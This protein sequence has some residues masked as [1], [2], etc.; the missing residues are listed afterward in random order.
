MQT[1]KLLVPFS[2]NAWTP[3]VSL[4][5]ADRSTAEGFHLHYRLKTN[6]P[7]LFAEL[8]RTPAAGTPLRRDELWRTTCFEAFFGVADS[9]AYF[10]L[11]LTPSGDWAW[12]AFDDYRKGM[13]KPSLASGD[14]PRII[15]VQRNE[16]SVD[17]EAFVPIRCFESL[18][19]D[20]HW[21]AAVLDRSDEPTYWALT[22]RG[23]A[24]DFHLRG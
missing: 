21:P 13:R 5:F 22:H 20:S 17:L 15:R 14:E 6:S 12:Y 1:A 8:I 9:P 3:G 10:E 23:P 11:N 2:P 19:L 7:H 16:T 18:A 4:E 24:P